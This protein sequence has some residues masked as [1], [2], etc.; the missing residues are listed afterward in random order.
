MSTI[1]PRLIHRVRSRLRPAITLGAQLFIVDQANCTLLV[2]PRYS[3]RWQ[4]PGGGVDPGETAKEAALRETFE[5]TGLRVEADPTLFGLYF[6]TLLNRRDHVAVFLCPDQPPLAAQSLGNPSLE[7]AG[8]LVA[9]LDELPTDLAPGTRR[10]IA[11]FHGADKS[12]LW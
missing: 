12:D 8:I 6:N 4:F 10:R 2:K 7:I 1:L 5:E 3:L 9:P 11:E